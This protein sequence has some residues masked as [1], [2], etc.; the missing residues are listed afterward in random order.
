MPRRQSGVGYMFATSKYRR[1]RSFQA[2][3]WMEPVAE[4]LGDISG[5][6][7]LPVRGSA[8]ES[9]EGRRRTRTQAQIP[10]RGT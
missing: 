5:F 9:A 4:A 7:A 3:R 6:S 10:W 1:A 8:R 2:P